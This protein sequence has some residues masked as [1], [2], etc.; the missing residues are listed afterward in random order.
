[1]R[2]DKFEN[3]IEYFNN[4]FSLVEN[5]AFGKGVREK[6]YFGD[7][8]NKVCR[9][10]DNVNDQE[11]RKIAHVFPELVGNKS[12]FSYYECDKCNQFFGDRLEN[13]LGKFLGASRIFMN[14]KGKGGKLNHK[15]ESIEI[16]S[17][18]DN[19]V[20]II[21]N[22]WEDAL[23]ID[24][25]RKSVKVNT[26]SQKYK[27]IS[28]YKCF[29]KMAISIV[30]DEY[31]DDFK[32]T[33]SFIMS[34]KSDKIDDETRLASAKILYTF[35]PGAINQVSQRALL[36]VRNDWFNYLIPRTENIPFMIFVITIGNSM[37][38]VSIHSD[39][40][41]KYLKNVGFKSMRFPDHLDDEY[42]QEYGESSYGTLDLSSNE[43][44]ESDNNINLSFGE[45]IDVP[46]CVK[47]S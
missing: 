33:I 6:K 21:V 27:P 8:N 26:K 47:I 31:L 7:K 34:D 18:M 22:S 13:D 2:K 3:N 20:K 16:I 29:L 15:E 36:F 42:V 39:N 45:K 19:T 38:Q 4:N 46:L 11:F 28:V 30:P 17:Q 43:I 40:D 9:Y 5:I 14:I 24:E 35:T 41:M 12:V 32:K 10:C 37:F 1:M 44:K 25:E 23:E